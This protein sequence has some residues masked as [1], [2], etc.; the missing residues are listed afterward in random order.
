[1][2][3]IFA[4]LRFLASGKFQREDGDIHGIA[5][6]TMSRLVHGVLRAIADLKPRF[7]QFPEE[8][9]FR[10]IKDAFYAGYGFPGVIGAIDCTHV[11]IDN[12][13]GPDPEL[14]RNRKGVFSINV[15]M[16]ADDRMMVRNVVASWMGSVHDSRIF[17]ESS[18]KH[19]ILEN[20]P[21]GSRSVLLGDRGYPCL[22]YLMTPLPNPQT[23]SERRYN[24]SQ[25]QTRMVVE[26]VFGVLKRRFPC[27]KHL[28]FSPE[29]ACIAIVA[30]AVL[31]NLAMEKNDI[32]DDAN[33]DQVQEENGGE[34]DENARPAN[35]QGAA[36]R[37][38]I[39]AEYFA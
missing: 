28:R 13:G 39:I 24:T 37:R 21:A 3:Q 35:L 25:S 16:V 32:E 15:Q 4:T 11:Q 27:L 14:Y 6:S 18:L 5:Q 38:A 26:R 34:P 1:M 7:I 8:R 33:L 9:E 31:H 19:A 2:F 36:R 30:C 20:L 12:P 17:S 10:R 22:P 29:K 23:A